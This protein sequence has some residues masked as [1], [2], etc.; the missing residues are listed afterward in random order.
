MKDKIKCT[1]PSVAE[2][3]VRDAVG[4]TAHDRGHGGSSLGYLM[5]KMH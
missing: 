2:L 3:E 4:A 1:E 5:R